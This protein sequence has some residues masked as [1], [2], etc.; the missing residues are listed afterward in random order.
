[1]NT[2][3]YYFSGTGN[4]LSVAKELQKRLTDSN[5]IPIIKLLNESKIQANGNIIG[6]VFPVHALTVPVAVRMFLRKLDLSSAEYIFIVA[7]R[8]G[9]LFFALIYGI[10][11]YKRPSL[12]P[13]L[14]ILH[15]LIYILPMLKLLT[16]SQ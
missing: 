11:L 9:I 12:L 16:I 15:L 14:A 5:L 2:E 8:M 4:S 7:T 10:A 6:V 13:W 1:M 3:I